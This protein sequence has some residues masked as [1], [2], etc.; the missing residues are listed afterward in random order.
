MAQHALVET[1]CAQRTA[2]DEHRLFPAIESH[3][4]EGFGLGGFGVEQVLSNGVARET[5]VFGGEEAL[6]AVVGHADETRPFGQ[7]L[8][9][10]AGIRILFL[11]QGGDAHLL[12]DVERGP[13]GVTAHS[14]SHLRLKVF[15]D[16]TG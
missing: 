2:H 3:G 14:H 9:G 15:D 11:K 16:F 8:V 12:G 1:A 5:D 13:A 6:H 7:K 10:H 4:F